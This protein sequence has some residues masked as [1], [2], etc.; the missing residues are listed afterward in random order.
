MTCIKLAAFATDAL[1]ALVK[2]QAS[3]LLCTLTQTCR[4]AA[5]KTV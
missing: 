5:I 4:Y 2:Q 3:Q 1:F